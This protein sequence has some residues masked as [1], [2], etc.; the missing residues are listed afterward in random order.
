MLLDGL[1]NWGFECLHAECAR[2][3]PIGGER[4]RLAPVALVGGSLRGAYT[5]EA[6][7]FLAALDGSDDGVAVYS[8][9]DD[10]PA[11]GFADSG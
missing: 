11:G 10:A 4:E 1:G 2:R 7:G 8:A 9:C 5:D 6:D 3:E